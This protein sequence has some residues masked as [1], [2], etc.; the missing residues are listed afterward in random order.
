MEYQASTLCRWQPLKWEIMH[1]QS[2]RTVSNCSTSPQVLH[3]GKLQLIHKLHHIPHWTPPHECLHILK[4]NNFSH[5][6]YAMVLMSIDDVSYF[7]SS[8]SHRHFPSLHPFLWMVTHCI[9]VNTCFS[10]VHTWNMLAQC[11]KQEDVSEILTS[12]VE[13][14]VWHSWTAF[15]YV[16]CVSFDLRPLWI[17]GRTSTEPHAVKG[18]WD[19][20]QTASQNA[21]KIFNVTYLAIWS[22]RVFLSLG[23]L[24]NEI[25]AFPPSCSSIILGGGGRT[26]SATNRFGKRPTVRRPFAVIPREKSPTT[27]T[28]VI[29]NIWR[30]QLL[31]N[32]CTN[33]HS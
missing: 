7:I 4:I 27:E 15:K 24:V 25:T 12:T 32:D 18:Q 33:F 14:S 11:W 26:G 9:T 22:Y 13:S 20:D 28:E 29:R 31:C 8:L 30:L 5:T 10:L 6:N 19:I 17:H 16:W 2:C 3:Y 1:R 23:S 21:I